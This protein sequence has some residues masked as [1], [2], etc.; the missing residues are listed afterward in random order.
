MVK[1]AAA[2]ETQQLAKCFASVTRSHAKTF[3][4]MFKTCAKCFSI[5]QSVTKKIETALKWAEGAICR[6]ATKSWRSSMTKLCSLFWRKMSSS[7]GNILIPRNAC[8]QKHTIRQTHTAHN[9]PRR[10][11]IKMWEQ[12]MQDKLLQGEKMAF[13]AH[14]SYTLSQKKHADFETV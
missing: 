4:I 13:W 3:A 14:V 2:C 7:F 1:V 5:K 12:K 8:T 9:R 10:Q 11:L 6:T